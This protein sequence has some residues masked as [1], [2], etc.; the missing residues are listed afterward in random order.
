MRREGAREEEKWATVASEKMMEKI[1]HGCL[2]QKE[3]KMGHSCLTFDEARR[4]GFYTH[5][6]DKY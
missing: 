6:E 2:T 5:F 4:E 1:G 3:E